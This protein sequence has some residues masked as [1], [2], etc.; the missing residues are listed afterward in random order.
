MS[1]QYATNKSR[2]LYGFVG[3]QWEETI[4]S[5]VDSALEFWMVKLPDHHANHSLILWI[6]ADDSILGWC[7]P[8]TQEMMDV[9]RCMDVLAL[10]EV[11]WYLAG[12]LS[13][14]L[15]ELASVGDMQLPQRRSN[16]PSV[17]PKR[18][19]KQDATDD[20]DEYVPKTV[21]HLARRMKKE[22]D[23]ISPKGNTR[24]QQRASPQSHTPQYDIDYRKPPQQQLPQ[25]SPDPQQYWPNRSVSQTTQEQ[26]DTYVRHR[27]DAS[28]QVQPLVS[29][30]AFGQSSGPAIY[31]NDPCA[32][33][34]LVPA[35]AV[36]AGPG[37]GSVY[38]YQ[39]SREGVGTMNL[40]VD[41]GLRQRTG[42]IG[43]GL[44]PSVGLA[45]N[46]DQAFIW[47]N[48]PASFE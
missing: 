2:I 44:N 14:I 45:S 37:I 15:H 40:D 46:V 39:T 4:V 17:T 11:R 6:Y 23:S 43:L 8:A 7:D 26:Y 38:S 33:A 20:D 32:M 12:R 3:Q 47:S 19:R 5:E 21:G 25:L 30:P 24:V 35:R 41:M 1:H 48:A 31:G 28:L 27:S 42:D 10:A 18:E 13:D 36:G 16:S 34:S 29:V 9:R 22:A